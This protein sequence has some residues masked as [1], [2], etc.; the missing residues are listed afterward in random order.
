[1]AQWDKLRISG[2]FVSGFNEL[3]VLVFFVGF[4]GNKEII[5]ITREFAPLTNSRSEG[6]KS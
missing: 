6:T 1:M 2:I 4:D 3:F 5:S